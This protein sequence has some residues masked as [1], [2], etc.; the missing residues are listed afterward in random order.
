M[1]RF[2]PHCGAV[3]SRDASDAFSGDV[4]PED[5]R[6]IYA[7]EKARLE[8]Q[9]RIKAEQSQ[10]KT[11][12]FGIGCLALVGLFVVLWIIGS[13]S[14]NKSSPGSDKIE[15]YVYSEEFVKD[16]LRAPSTA[17]FCG[18]SGATVVTLGGDS[19]QV[20]GWVDAQNAFGAMIRDDFVC[21]LHKTGDKWYRDDI[22]L[23]PR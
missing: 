22:S 10:K 9:G 7:E 5:R 19:Y 3:V 4:S 15:A 12:C 18:F 11:G 14:D 1:A 21:K 17:K 8:A 6:R 2:C 13:L 16:R 23:V 20:N